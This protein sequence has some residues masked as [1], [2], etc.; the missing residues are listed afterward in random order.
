MNFIENF[1]KFTK[2]FSISCLVRSDREWKG[3]TFWIEFHNFVT[4]LQMR[5]TFREHLGNF[6]SSYEQW[7]RYHITVCQINTVKQMVHWLTQMFWFRK[8]QITSIRLQ[9]NHSESHSC[10]ACLHFSLHR[11]NC[12]PYTFYYKFKNT[13][14]MISEV[15]KQESRYPVYLWTACNSEIT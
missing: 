9:F 6:W 1:R 14:N 7:S 2:H 13:N 5:C 12:V 15:C 11:Y 10:T 3:R 4:P 8:V